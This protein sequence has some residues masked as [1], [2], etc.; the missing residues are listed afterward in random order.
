MTSR[1]NPSIREP[2]VAATRNAAANAKRL[3]VLVFISL[4][5]CGGYAKLLRL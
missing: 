5:M 3:L 2:A 4:P 1:I